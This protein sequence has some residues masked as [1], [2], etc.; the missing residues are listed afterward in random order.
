MQC[1][2]FLADYLNGDT[3]YKIAYPEHNLVR[4]KNQLKLYQDVEAHSDEMNRFIEDYI[5]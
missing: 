5:P 4:T 3:Y 2:R 1:I